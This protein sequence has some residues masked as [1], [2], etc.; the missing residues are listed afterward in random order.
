MPC[1]MLLMGSWFWFAADAAVV[2]EVFHVANYAN[3]FQTS[4]CLCYPIRCTKFVEVSYCIYWVV[5]GNKVFLHFLFL[6]HTLSIH[7]YQNYIS[8]ASLKLRLLHDTSMPL[9]IGCSFTCLR[10]FIR[11]IHY[12]YA[13]SLRNIVSDFPLLNFT[14]WKRPFCTDAISSFTL[15]RF[16][17]TSPLEKENE[18]EKKTR[19]QPK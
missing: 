10:L 2:W 6:S 11:F 1:K 16:N 13:I 7:A 5:V 17:L 3:I 9:E 19:T 4:F 14:R 15:V 18:I 12:I 8:P